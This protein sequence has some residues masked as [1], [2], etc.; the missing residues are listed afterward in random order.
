VLEAGRVVLVEG[1]RAGKAVVMDVREAVVVRD[2]VE[3][4]AVVVVDCANVAVMTV[5]SARRKLECI[6]S[7]SLI[8]CFPY[9]YRSSKMKSLC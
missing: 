3:S 9:P 4:V 6:L 8:V 7:S 5:A 2:D 1:R